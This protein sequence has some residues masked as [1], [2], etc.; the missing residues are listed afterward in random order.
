MKELDE[1]KHY[2][3]LAESKDHEKSS[4]F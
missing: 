3:V 1:E 4:V 2:V